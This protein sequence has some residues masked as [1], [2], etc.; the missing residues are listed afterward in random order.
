MARNSGK[1]VRA[2]ATLLLT[3]L[4]LQ[5]RPIPALPVHIDCSDIVFRLKLLTA[6]LYNETQTLLEEYNAHHGWTC[7]APAIPEHAAAAANVSDPS[8]LLADA[9]ARSVSFKRALAKVKEYQILEWGNPRSVAPHLDQVRGNLWSQSA[10]L[11]VL[12]RLA[13]PAT[14]G[15]PV[16]GTP[17]VPDTPSP[18][19]Y[20]HAHGFAK[21]R[22]GCEQIVELR[23]WLPE[24]LGVLTADPGPCHRPAGDRH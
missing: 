23:H 17:V 18:P 8:E 3:L 10:L 2:Q 19:R 13:Y 6:M 20:F 21:K 24:V 15:T 5:G 16:S 22:F 9:Y 7:R 14:P 1:A 11:E 12:I 4:A